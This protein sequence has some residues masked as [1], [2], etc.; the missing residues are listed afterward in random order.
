MSGPA[1]VVALIP[2]ARQRDNAMA[3]VLAHLRMSD[4]RPLTKDETQRLRDAERRANR[5]FGV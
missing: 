5:R 2:A 3:E 1:E 4:Q